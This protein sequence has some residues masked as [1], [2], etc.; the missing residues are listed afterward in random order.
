MHNSKENWIILKSIHVGKTLIIVCF[1]KKMMDQFCWFQENFRVLRKCRAFSYSRFFFYY[2]ALNDKKTRK[3]C[4]K[5]SE[6][7]LNMAFSN[8]FS[9]LLLLVTIGFSK[10]KT[11]ELKSFSIG[12]LN[13]KEKWFVFSKPKMF[14]LYIGLL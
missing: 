3:I 11:F 1:F 13:T 4:R 6:L 14:D 7:K 8:C 12:Q 10:K 9:F 2:I 5:P